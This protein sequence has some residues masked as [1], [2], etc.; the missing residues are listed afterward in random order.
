MEQRLQGW[1][2]VVWLQPCTSQWSCLTVSLTL[3]TLRNTHLWTYCKS[4]LPA[5]LF[6][7]PHQ[8]FVCPGCY[9]PCFHQNFHCDL[10]LS[11]AVLP[12]GEVFKRPFDH[13]GSILRSLSVPFARD[14]IRESAASQGLRLVT[15]EAGWCWHTASMVLTYSKLCVRLRWGQ[16]AF[17]GV[18]AA[19]HS[20]VPSSPQLLAFIFLNLPSSCFLRF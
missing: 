8:E 4:S 6:P 13:K 11:R 3:R 10:I 9:V 15:T 16:V 19:S 2:K 20:Y 14:Q 18:S 7:E 17:P 5:A 12:G 1:G